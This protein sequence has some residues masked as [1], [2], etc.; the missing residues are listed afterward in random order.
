M[1]A[2]LVAPSACQ[3]AG[4]IRPG[5]QGR[6][7]MLGSKCVGALDAPTSGFVVPTHLPQCVGASASP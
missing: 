7:V 6:L 4:G 2:S 3:V 1:R 5:F